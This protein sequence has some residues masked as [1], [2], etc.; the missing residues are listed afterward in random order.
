MEMENKRKQIKSTKDES[1]IKEMRKKS[2]QN[3]SE[4]EYL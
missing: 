3:T 4:R 1:K 2:K